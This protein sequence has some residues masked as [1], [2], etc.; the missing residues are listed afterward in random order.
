MILSHV[1]LCFE[2]GGS[3]LHIFDK[4][5]D[6][7]HNPDQP[8]LMFISRDESLS[9]Y[10]S[11]WQADQH[12]NVLLAH[13]PNASDSFVASAKTAWVWNSLCLM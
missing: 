4:L 8:N 6:W 3:S 2:T 9:R 5:L 7:S 12:K 13:P 10:L 11:E 1:F